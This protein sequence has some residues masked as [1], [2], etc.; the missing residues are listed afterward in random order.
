MTNDKARMTKEIRSTNEAARARSPL[1]AACPVDSERSIDRPRPNFVIRASSFVIA[2]ALSSI[3]HQLSTPTAHAQPVTVTYQGRVQSHGTNFTGAGQFK[4][5]LVASTNVAVTATVTAN[6]VGSFITSYIVTSGGNGYV[7]PPVVTVTGG[8]GSGATATAVVSGGAVTAIN[9]VSPGGGYTS[10]PTVTLAPP[11][12]TILFTTH[13]SNDGTSSAG[14]QPT[15]AVTTSVTN[16]LFTL[17]LGDTTL[18]NMATLAAT[19]F[20]QANLQLR[21]WFN[22][23]VNGFAMIVP[24][25]KLT[26]APYAI[27]SGSASNL[28]G[29]L[30]AAQITGVLSNINL[31]SAPIFSGT[32]TAGGFVGN[33][34]ALTN[35]PIPTSFNVT[36]M[37][38]P[39]A[40]YET[41]VTAGNHFFLVTTN[42]RPAKF[43]FSS[44]SHGP[45]HGIL[46]L[47]ALSGDVVINPNHDGYG[48]PGVIQLGAT[49]H[50]DND[51]FLQ[52]A[53][54]PSAPASTN[55]YGFSHPLAFRSLSKTNRM[56]HYPGIVGFCAN[57]IAG[58]TENGE[59]RIYA[60]VPHW[61][62]GNMNPTNPST[63]GV[64]VSDFSTNGVFN[65]YRVVSSAY[66]AATNGFASYSTTT[67]TAITPTGWT[68]IWST[69][70]ANVRV[71][72]T[73]QTV[74][75]KNRSNAIVDTLTA[76]NGSI[77][78]PIQPGWAISAA[79]GLSGTSWPQ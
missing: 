41:L 11:P 77:V 65:Q 57:D 6:R 54:D 7:T 28:L 16:G 35:L 19:V 66:I 52:Y 13:W 49:A 60:R 46:L 58:Q 59:I 39:P 71:T 2:I 14:N 12:E 26:L 40:E 69:N 22:N 56:A 68:N 67:A 15:A 72:A 76:F 8:G 18:A 63:Q 32:V 31:P 3:L 25:Q 17:G 47:G 70:N 75:V 53:S 9:P 21:T 51:I 79:G 62:E 29:S 23:G 38:I 48:G 44:V 34:G 36:N 45:L 37:V 55:Y 42:A 50:P 64:L 1:H 5:A 30:P 73:G 74:T 24:A 33:G 27:M 43:G 78:I 61:V 4:F 20:N 10:T